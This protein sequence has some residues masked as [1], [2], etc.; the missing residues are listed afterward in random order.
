MV[1]AMD[2][3]R[4]KE[5]ARWERGGYYCKEGLFQERLP[6]GGNMNKQLKEVSSFL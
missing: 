4:E 3:N 2:R 6:L 5:E 1:K